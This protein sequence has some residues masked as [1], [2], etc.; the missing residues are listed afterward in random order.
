MSAVEA[1]SNKVHNFC[2]D[3]CSMRMDKFYRFLL[4]FEN[5]DEI[6]STTCTGHR[7][8]ANLS[9]MRKAR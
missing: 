4:I 9:Y 6:E 5:D 2:F 7:G 3:Y 8:R 1:R